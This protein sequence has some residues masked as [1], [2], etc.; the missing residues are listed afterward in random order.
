MPETS[1]RYFRDD[2]GTSPFL[3]WLTTLQS[4]NAKA[5]EKCL[6]ILDLLQRFGR[7]LRR[8]HADSLRDGVYELR[9]RVGRVNYRILYGFVGKD[10]VLVSHGLTKEKNVPGREIDL[11]AMRLTLYRSAPQ[12]YATEEDIDDD[13]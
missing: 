6:F 7:E 5:F 11:A 9:T 2:D 10:V 3:D 4:H 12:R 1:I 13:N 8:P